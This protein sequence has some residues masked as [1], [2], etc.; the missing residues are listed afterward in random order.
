MGVD[1]WLAGRLSGQRA[2]Q[3]VACRCVLGNP[4]QLL[5]MA[6]FKANHPAFPTPALLLL[7]AGGQLHEGGAAHCG[8]GEPL[9]PQLGAPCLPRCVSRP[10]LSLAVQWSHAQ[11]MCASLPPPQCH[12]RNILHRDI[13]P[14]EDCFCNKGTHAA[15]GADTA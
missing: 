1:G 3:A 5:V 7:R 8:P 12:Q 10:H 9:W 15:S 13:K 11:L 14:G 4:S 2:G 6:A